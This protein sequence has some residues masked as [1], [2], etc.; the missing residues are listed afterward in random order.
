MDEA[1]WQFL[2]HGV[3]KP[4]GNSLPPLP[5]FI[6]GEKNAIS[7]SRKIV[8]LPDFHGDAWTGGKMISQT[9]EFGKYTTVNLKELLRRSS[10]KEKHL[11]S[12]N[13]KPFIQNC[14]DNFAGFALKKQMGLENAASAVTKECG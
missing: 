2:G 9:R 4:H 3:H 12:T 1:L 11:H 14:V 13:F 6:E 5:V 8:K 10:V 7:L